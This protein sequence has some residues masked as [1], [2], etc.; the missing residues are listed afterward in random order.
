RLRGG[1]M[2]LELVVPERPERTGVGDDGR[3]RLEVLLTKA[4]GDAPVV[5]RLAADALDRADPVV[6]PAAH[7]TVGRLERVRLGAEAE[8]LRRPVLPPPADPVAPLEQQDLLAG[9]D[10]LVGRHA[11][12]E[13]AADHDRVPV[14]R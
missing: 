6:V 3:V 1:V 2:A 13:P 7:P 14:L 12:A 9:G 11:A 10:E 5:D 4:K 8:P